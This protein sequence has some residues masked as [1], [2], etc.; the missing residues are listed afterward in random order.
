M[1]LI[2][3]DADRNVAGVEVKASTA[4]RQSGFRSLSL[5]RDDLCT[6]FRLGIVLYAG[7]R[8]LPF[9]DRLL[10]LPHSA[11]WAADDMT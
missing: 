7:Q 10:A 9:G 3:E 6:R 8:A 1:D 4:V 2:L 5:L 11:V